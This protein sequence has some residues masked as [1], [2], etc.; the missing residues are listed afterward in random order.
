MEMRG[1]TYVRDLAREIW[2]L[3]EC[4]GEGENLKIH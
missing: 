3:T 2:R 1:E 4:E